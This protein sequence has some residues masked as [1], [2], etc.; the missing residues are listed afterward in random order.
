MSSLLYSNVLPLM[1]LTN[2]FRRHCSNRQQQRQ[3]HRRQQRLFCGV[4]NNNKRSNPVRVDSTV[5]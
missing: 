5:Y 1:S 3:Q 4:N 2:L